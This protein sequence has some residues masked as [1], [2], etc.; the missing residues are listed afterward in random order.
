MQ[1]ISSSGFPRRI[2]INKKIKQ[3]IANYSKK[4]ILYL[5]NC[6]NIIK[7]KVALFFYKRNHKNI[8]KIKARS[9]HIY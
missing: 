7:T 5:Y 4:E 6:K 8:L 2:K 3:K 9:I 1:I